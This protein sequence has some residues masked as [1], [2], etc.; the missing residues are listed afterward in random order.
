MLQASSVGVCPELSVLILK[1]T[2]EQE[3]IRRGAGVIIAHSQTAIWREVEKVGFAS[4]RKKINNEEH[5][6]IMG[7][8][9]RVGG[10]SCFFLLQEHETRVF[11][12]AKRQVMGKKQ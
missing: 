8:M 11:S 5:D 4:F 7:G 12:T 1:D 3:G 10:S 6:K 9:G 2:A